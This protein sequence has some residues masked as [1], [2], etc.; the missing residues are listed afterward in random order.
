MLQIP[1]GDRAMKTLGI[2]GGMSWESTASYYALVNQGVRERLGGLHSAS[3]VISSYDFAR[4]EELQSS[5]RWDEMAAVLTDTARKLEMAGAD[6]FL[7]ATNTMHEVA[8]EV[9]SKV[10]IP[11]LHIADALGDALVADGIDTVGLLGTRFTMERPFYTEILRARHGVSSLIPDERDRQT[12]HRVIYDEL[13]RG[14][15]QE[16][17][18]IDYVRIMEDL[19][20]KGAEAIAFACTEIGLL[21]RDTD[22]DLPV[23]DTAVIHADAAV[24]WMLEEQCLVPGT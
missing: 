10:S 1:E 8:D 6:G 15:A 12:V 11:L 19:G 13:C 5:G 18:R 21:V 24:K 17:S 20:K 3:L 16:D 9:A 4:I 7:I 14:V 2:I 23:Y 22:T